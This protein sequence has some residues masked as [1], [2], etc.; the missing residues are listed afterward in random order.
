MFDYRQVNRSIDPLNIP[1]FPPPLPNAGSLNGR[2]GHREAA[3]AAQAPEGGA[4]FGAKVAV[5]HVAL[6]GLG[7]GSQLDL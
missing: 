1:H 6:D 4:G 7:N 2:L 5:T 3:L